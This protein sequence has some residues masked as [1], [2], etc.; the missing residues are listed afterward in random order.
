[1]SILENV[2]LSECSRCRLPRTQGS[3][4]R[5]EYARG[6]IEEVPLCNTC[7]SIDPVVTFP[8]EPPKRKPAVSKKQKK[9]AD[10]QEERNAW[11]FKATK[12]KASGSMPWQKS[13]GSSQ[14]IRY[15]SKGTRSMQFIVHIRDLQKVRSECH[16]QQVPLLPLQFMDKSFRIVDEWT[17]IP[18]VHL[19][20]ILEKLDAASNK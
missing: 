12:H 15:D 5:A 3:V 10:R 1:M 7:T 18:T 8:A 14:F 4:Y 9:A 13:D 17:L 2:L 20:R 6:K 16:G 19:S 11:Q